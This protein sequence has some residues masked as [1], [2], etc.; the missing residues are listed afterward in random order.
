MTTSRTDYDIT[1]EA[2]E[3]GEKEAK[4]KEASV[5]SSRPRKYGMSYYEAASQLF[6]DYA[7]YIDL[8]DVDGIG[9]LYSDD[10]EMTIEIAGAQ[11]AGLFSGRATIMAFIGSAMSGLTDQRRHVIT[12]VRVESVS[13][14]ELTVTAFLTLVIIE[15]GELRVQTTGVYRLLAVRSPDVLRIRRMHLS[16]DRPY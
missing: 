9:S 11:T 1:K 15:G 5:V 4:E 14:D 13:E 16:L 7:W 6:A 8:R 10:A 2:K 12:N 3:R